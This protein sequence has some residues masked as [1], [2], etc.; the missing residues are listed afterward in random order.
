MLVQ[1]FMHFVFRSMAMA[2]QVIRVDMEQMILIL[3]ALEASKKPKTGDGPSSSSAM[4]ISGRDVALSDLNKSAP[5]S[6]SPQLILRSSHSGLL[7]APATSLIASPR[8]SS[9][10]NPYAWPL[11]QA[12]AVTDTPSCALTS[13]DGGDKSLDQILKE[14]RIGNA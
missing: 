14:L 9:I 13:V 7:G 11:P 6:S 1:C 2:L 4:G 3:T 12:E 10:L 5:K 8:T